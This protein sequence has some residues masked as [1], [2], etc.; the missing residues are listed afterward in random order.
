MVFPLQVKD[1]IKG[2]DRVKDSQER[3]SNINIDDVSTI[4]I[5]P[6]RMTAS[7][8]LYNYGNHA[9]CTNQTQQ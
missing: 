5:T 2:K 1:A 3:M 8:P 4:P 7:K 6:L 9:I